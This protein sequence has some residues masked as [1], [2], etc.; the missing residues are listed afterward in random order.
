[1]APIK[2]P[3]GMV[4][5]ES[6]GVVSGASVFATGKLTHVEMEWKQFVTP[7]KASVPATMGELPGEA[8]AVLHRCW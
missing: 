7:P 1:M 2:S 6:L 5:I 8:A 4:K 3:A